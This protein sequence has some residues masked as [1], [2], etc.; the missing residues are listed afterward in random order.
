MKT[1]ALVKPI[2]ATACA[3][4]LIGF[5]SFPLL[6]N[7]QK[8]IGEGISQQQLVA[9]AQAATDSSDSGVTKDETV[10]VKLAN[11]GTLRSASSTVTLKNAGSL[12]VIA[13]TSS[14]YNIAC[15]DDDLEWAAGAGI[16]AWSAQGE[17]VTYTGDVDTSANALPLSVKVTYKL[18]GEP[19]SAA[20][21]V[22]KSGAVTISYAFENATDIPFAAIAT[23]EMDDDVFSEISV[24]NGRTMAGTDSTTA[25]GVCFP[26]LEAQLNVDDLDI[27]SS[28]EI[29]AQAKNFSLEAATIMVTASLFDDIDVSDVDMG[30]MDELDDS[31]DSM[32][33]AVDELADGAFT[34][35]DNLYTLADGADELADGASDLAEGLSALSDLSTGL[36]TLSTANAQALAGLS[37]ALDAVE[38]TEEQKAV[39]AQCLA[40]LTA[41]DEGL[42]TLAKQMSPETASAT[43]AGAQAI[44]EGNATLATGATSLTEGAYTLA[45][46]LCQF[47]SEGV[48]VL[49]DALTGSDSTLKQLQSLPDKIETLSD[50]AAKYQTFTGKDANMKGTVSFIYQVDAVS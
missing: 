22:G 21:I 20:D 35:A 9:E 40:G 26:G 49:A 46:A 28:F 38:M 16:L 47:N 42:A 13:D 29:T 43:V 11:D 4:A 39:V 7:V 19:V 25:V 15:S 32:E 8:A 3:A 37:A 27:P 10:H 5:A 41:T 6:S 30:D 48:S 24:D 17:N 45:E 14:L 31:M 50:R 36:S 23:L 12:P 44:A 33:E 1:N 18:D 34:I 2:A